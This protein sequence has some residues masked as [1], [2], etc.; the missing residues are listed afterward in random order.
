MA[1]S[2]ELT[3]DKIRSLLSGLSETA[4]PTSETLTRSLANMRMLR[5]ECMLRAADSVLSVGTLGSL[6]GQD[7]SLVVSGH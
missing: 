6:L 3:D 1:L 7:R 5:R 2:F 4:Y